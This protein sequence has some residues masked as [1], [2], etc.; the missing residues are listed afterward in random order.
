MKMY[1]FGNKCPLNSTVGLPGGSMVNNLPANLE[2]PGLIPRLGRSPGE[3]N[4]N[5]LQYSSLG[6][7]TGR[8]A[9]W[10]TVHGVAKESAMTQQL[11]NTPPNSTII[12]LYDHFSFCLCR[13]LESQR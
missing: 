10:A 3:G 5:P 7:P 1:K 13:L 2:D 8:E 6:N 4:G 9:W 12:I 11:N